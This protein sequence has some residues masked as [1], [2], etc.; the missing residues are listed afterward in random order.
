MAHTR[1]GPLRV[2]EEVACAV[3]AFVTGL[4]AIP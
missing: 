3:A 2:V 1:A 4:V